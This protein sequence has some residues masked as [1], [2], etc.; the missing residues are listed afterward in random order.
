MEKF[1]RD[2]R[3]DAFNKHQYDSAIF[4]GDKL[5][6]LTSIVLQTS[7]DITLG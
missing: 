1:L 7:L 4:V 2:W 5:L 3:Q 6:A